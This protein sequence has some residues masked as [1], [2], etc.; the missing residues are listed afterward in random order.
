MKDKRLIYISAVKG[1]YPNVNKPELAIV[2]RS[3]CGKS[4]FINSIFKTKIAHTSSKPGKTITI[5]FFN[6]LDKL[7][8][9][10][11]PG[12]GFAKISMSIQKN[13]QELIEDYL[14]NRRELKAI[15]ILSDI[16]RGIEKE[17]ISLMEF[18][19]QINIKYYMIYTKIDKLSNNE[20]RNAKNK[21]LN[22]IKELNIMKEEDIFFISSSKKTGIDKIEFLLNT[23][24]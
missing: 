23:L 1:Q 11:L 3:N 5:N 13:W 8:I 14:I 10:D 24:I 7:T 18:L 12:Y 22:E 15:F 6:Y 9:V 17:E 16:R 21:I 19:R 2:G 20:L 4:T